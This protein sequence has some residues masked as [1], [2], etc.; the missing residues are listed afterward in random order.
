MNKKT[1]IWIIAII[2]ALVLV[3]SLTNKKPVVADTDTGNTGS[4]ANQNQQEQYQVLD[5]DDDVFDTIES[6]LDVIE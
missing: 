4:D 2:I 1:L 6:T 3:F 5:T